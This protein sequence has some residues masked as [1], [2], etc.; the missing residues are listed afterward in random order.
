[1]NRSAADAA[2]SPACELCRRRGLRLT[3]HHLIPRSRHR[4]PRTRRRFTREQMNGRIAMVCFA[5]HGMIHATLTE[6]QLA[7][8]YPTL[9]ALR[10]HPD[11]ARFFAWVA[12]QPTHRRVTVRRAAAYAQGG[13]RRG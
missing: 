7:D 1:M 6:R 3:R 4:K 13:A 11:L 9:D 8:D 5:C 10:A 12:D 2:A